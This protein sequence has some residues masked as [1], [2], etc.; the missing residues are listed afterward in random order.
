MN[1]IPNDLVKLTTKS[2]YFDENMNFE[3]NHGWGEPRGFAIDLATY[4]TEGYNVYSNI[5]AFLYSNS[6]NSNNPLNLNTGNE[7]RLFGNN[8]T[9]IYG[10]LQSNSVAVS[11]LDNLSNS[12]MQNDL[13]RSYIPAGTQIGNV[14]NTGNSTGPHLHW[15]YRLGYQYWKNKSK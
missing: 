14:G 12:V 10:H 6:V 5:E 13:W 15:E 7:V 8:T 9:T 4:K 11:M 3:G 2:V 1:P